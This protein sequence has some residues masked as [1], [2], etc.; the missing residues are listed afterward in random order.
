MVNAIDDYTAQPGPFVA[1]GENDQDEEKKEDG[2]R[3]RRVDR[4]MP[5]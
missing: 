5:R 2:F 1:L 4:K 3:I